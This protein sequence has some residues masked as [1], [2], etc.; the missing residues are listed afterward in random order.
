M[1]SRPEGQRSAKMFG[2][3]RH[4][5]GT[6]AASFALP[7]IPQFGEEYRCSTGFPANAFTLLRSRE[8]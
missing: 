6:S 2:R 3:S 4:E 8:D 5:Q 7:E 1:H